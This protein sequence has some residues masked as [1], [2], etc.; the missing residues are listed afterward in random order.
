[1]IMSAILLQILLQFAEDIIFVFGILAIMPVSYLPLKALQPKPEQGMEAIR[2]MPYIM[3]EYPE[4]TK[5]QCD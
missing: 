3:L 4:S 1:M 2:S 5:K